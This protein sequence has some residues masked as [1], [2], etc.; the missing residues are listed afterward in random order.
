MFGLILLT[1]ILVMSV[2]MVVSVLCDMYKD[3]FKGIFLEM[4]KLPKKGPINFCMFYDN[5]GTN[6]LLFAVQSFHQSD[7]LISCLSSKFYDQYSSDDDLS[8]E[9]LM[10][11]SIPCDAHKDSFKDTFLEMN[12]F[13]KKELIN[14]W[15]FYDNEGTIQLLLWSDHFINPTIIYLIFGVNFITSVLVIISFSQGHLI[16]VNVQCDIGKD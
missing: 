2:L 13:T 4:N 16:V 10:V 9:H 8:Q 3:S 6:Q 1:S 14:F 15:K 5:E 12:K 11:V 7:H